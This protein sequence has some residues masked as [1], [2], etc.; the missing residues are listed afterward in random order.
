METNAKSFPVRSD[1]IFTNTT[2]LG[3]RGLDCTLQLRLELGF[4]LV[5]LGVDPGDH[6]G[7]GGEAPGRELLGVGD[8]ERAQPAGTRAVVAVIVALALWRQLAV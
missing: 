4:D 6:V 2:H 5:L 8:D 7:S 1:R 3:H